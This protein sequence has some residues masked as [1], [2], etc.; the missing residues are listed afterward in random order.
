MSC[1]FL[2]D[3]CKH[4]SYVV[5]PYLLTNSSQI[6]SFEKIANECSVSFHEVYI[7]IAKEDAVNGL[8]KQ[9]CWGEEGSKELTEKDRE[10]LTRRY[11]HME[12]EMKKYSNTTSINSKVGDIA[13]TYQSFLNAVQ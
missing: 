8:L 5:L 6:E 9:G 12:N 4:L 11:E 3:T 1:Y 10:E 2:S 13:T 7:E